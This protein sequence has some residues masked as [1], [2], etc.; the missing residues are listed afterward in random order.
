MANMVKVNVDTA[1]RDTFAVAA[2]VIHDAK[3]AIWGFKIL[4]WDVVSPL[5]G[6]AEAAKLGVALVHQLGFRQIIL[7]SDF[8]LVIKAIKM[9]PL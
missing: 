1:I 8:E 2:A 5:I 4:K 6:E 9:A 7:E 3:G